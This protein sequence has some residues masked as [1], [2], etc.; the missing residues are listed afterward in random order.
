MGIADN[1]LILYIW[2]DNGSSMEGTETGSFNEMTT[3]NGIPLPAEQQLKLIDAYGGIDGWG[4]PSMPAPLRLRLGLGRATRRSSGASRWPPT[5]AAPA[6]RWSSPG[7]SGSRTR[8]ACARQFTHVH[9]RRPHHPGGR[10]HP[11]AEGGGRDRADAH[12]RRRASPY[13]FDD[14]QRQGAATRSSTS[15]SSATGPCTRTAGSPAARLDR[16]PWRVDPAA[17]ARFGPGSGWDPDKDKWEL[18]NIDEDFSQ[19]E[20]PRRPAPRE[21]GRAESTVLG[22]GREVPRHPAR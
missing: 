19:A 6:T 21:A 18:Y 5:S 1:T 22:G 13:T 20:R 8:A 9:R 4:G 16:I 12:A 7:P 14:A 2:G 11:R 17:L 10:G 3:L 15:R